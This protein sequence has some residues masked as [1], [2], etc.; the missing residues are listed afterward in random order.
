MAIVAR[1]PEVDPD[2]TCVILTL[3]ETILL[4]LILRTEPEPHVWRT[5]E[6]IK[7]RDDIMQGIRKTGLGV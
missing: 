6:E 1:N 7:L 5:A 4:A 3:D 2:I